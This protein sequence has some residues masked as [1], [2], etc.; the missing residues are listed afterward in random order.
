MVS[1][2]R[3]IGYGVLMWLVPFVVAFAVFPL[4]EAA[5]PVFESIMAVTVATAV[6]VLGSRY[7]RLTAT[8]HV[9]EGLLVG[10][11]WLGMS[12][13]IDGPLMLLG[14]P[15]QMS[16]GE[17]MGDIGLTYVM[18]P[19]ITAGLGAAVASGLSRAE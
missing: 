19:V 10:L 8:A 11:I 2:R 1:W 3:A 17:Y 12:I 7:L 9:R 14:G 16:L 13:L 18:M 4:K 15:M 5:R 6:V